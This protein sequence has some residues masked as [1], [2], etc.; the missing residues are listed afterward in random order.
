M[1]F[2]N[3]SSLLVLDSP[4][5]SKNKSF[6]PSFSFEAKY[7][8]IGF[9]C[10]YTNFAIFVIKIIMENKINMRKPTLK[11]MISLYK[12]RGI[13]KPVTCAKMYMKGFKDSKKY[14]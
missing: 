4:I 5:F 8:F 3:R 10:D 13:K 11:S 9:M 2:F 14:K 12:K 7:S 1:R 6:F